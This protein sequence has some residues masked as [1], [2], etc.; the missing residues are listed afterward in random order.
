MGVNSV[1]TT[2]LSLVYN[3]DAASMFALH[4]IGLRGTGFGEE[5]LRA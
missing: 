5:E 1:N 3:P 2:D 4:E